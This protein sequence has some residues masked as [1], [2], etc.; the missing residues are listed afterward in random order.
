MNLLLRIYKETQ[1]LEVVQGAVGGKLTILAI[2]SAYCIIKE[3]GYSGYVH[4]GVGVQY[5]CPQFYF[6]KV[7]KINNYPKFIEVQLEQE[8]S[9]ESSREH[10]DSFIDLVCDKFPEEKY[11][12]LAKYSSNE[13]KQYEEIYKKQDEFM[14]EFE[15][16]INL[17]KDKEN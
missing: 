13:R 7:K 1:K 16:S 10:I 4:R 17:H 5:Q 6:Y 11:D 15:R 9:Q 3:N 8:W 2:D 14:K 12:P